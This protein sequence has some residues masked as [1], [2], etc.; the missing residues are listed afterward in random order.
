MSPICSPGFEAI[1]V[2]RASAMSSIATAV[3]DRLFKV[4]MLAS[5]YYGHENGDTGGTGKVATRDGMWE[6]Q[7]QQSHPQE[8]FS[9]KSVPAHCEVAVYWTSP[10][11]KTSWS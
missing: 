3:S 10:Q 8:P 9:S 6:Q 4:V 7:Q 11:T 5:E 1:E 2:P